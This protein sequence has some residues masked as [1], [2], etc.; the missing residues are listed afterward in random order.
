MVWTQAYWMDHKVVIWK[1]TKNYEKIQ[2]QS[3]RKKGTMICEKRGSK[4][5]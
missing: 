1:G 4:V 3:S 5:S 2:S